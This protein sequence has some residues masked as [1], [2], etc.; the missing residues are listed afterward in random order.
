MAQ[1]QVQTPVGAAIATSGAQDARMV[2]LRPPRTERIGEIWHALRRNPTAIFGFFLI[3]VLVLCAAFPSL[4][5]PYAPYG[6]NFDLEAAP[7]SWSHPFGCDIFG[8]DVL[9]RVIYGAR[10]DLTIAVFAV[11][12]SLTVG[13]LIGALS[14]YAGGLFDEFAM[15]VMDILQ[16]FP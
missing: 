3:G 1:T 11:V 2:S 16:G 8:Q 7:P 9:S 6:V 13:A 10:I 4:L 14:G 12:L 5:A 15:R